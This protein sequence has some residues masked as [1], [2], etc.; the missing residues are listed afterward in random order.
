MKEI[1]TTTVVRSFCATVLVRFSTFSLVLYQSAY[2]RP[3]C[4][5]DGEKRMQL[6]DGHAGEVWTDVLGWYQGEVTI[7]EDGWADFK[8]HERSVSI[9]AKKD[10]RGREEYG[11]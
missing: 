8:C 9:W 5:G 7:G 4:A 2:L 10:A 6:P 1:R 3:L 11:Q